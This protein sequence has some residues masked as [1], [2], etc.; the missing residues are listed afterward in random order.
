MFGLTLAIPKNDAN[1]NFERPPT[2][3]PLTSISKGGLAL[4]PEI[5]RGSFGK[6]FVG[7]YYGKMVAVKTIL[8]KGTD[9]DE[10]LNRELKVLKAARHE[11]LLKYVGT[12]R[13][14]ELD[15]ESSTLYIVTE[16]C[17][18]GDLLVL[19]T[20][21]ELQMNWTLRLR[22]AKQAA[23]AIQ[24]LHSATLIHR[25]IKSS[26]LLL[27]ENWNCKL[28]DFGMARLHPGKSPDSPI[29][30][31]RMTICG[32]NEY[33]SPELMFDEEY[34]YSADIFSFGMVLFEM[35]AR[36]AIGK[37]KFIL[38]RPSTKFQIDEQCLDEVIPADT[39]SSLLCLAKQCS[40]Y[41][42]VDR[43]PIEEVHDWLGDLQ[44]TF[45][46]GTNSGTTTNSTSSVTTTNSTNSTS[47]DV[48]SDCDGTV[49]QLPSGENG[50]EQLKEGVPSYPCDYV[51][52]LLSRDGAEL[53]SMF[54]PCGDLNTRPDSPSW[55]SLL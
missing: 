13:E 4:G 44:S 12:Y 14:I 27:D 24:F 21:T 49:F 37:D 17:T 39:P 6:V 15:N 3:N 25:D 1:D 30:L 11:N 46:S 29:K 28:A 22:I 55:S 5:G 45:N 9:S 43:P 32:T 42:Q 19:L 38:R 7:K 18:G 10:H 41:E 52:K 31:H 34:S 40:S 16:L 50:T 36:K 20:N 8:I 53:D 33:M 51:L 23:D 54:K 47:S 48:A 26:N 2:I 35:I